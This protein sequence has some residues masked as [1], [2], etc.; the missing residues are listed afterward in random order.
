LHLDGNDTTGLPLTW[1]K[2]L[3]RRA[4]IFSDPLRFTAHRVGAG[5]TAYEVLAI[6]VTRA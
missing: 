5:E 2:R 6:A 4:L 1:R 3:L